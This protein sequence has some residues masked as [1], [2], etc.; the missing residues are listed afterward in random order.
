LSRP[1]RAAIHCG[2]F[3]NVWQ[4]HAKFAKHW[5]PHPPRAKSILPMLGKNGPDLPNIGKTRGCGIL[6]RISPKQLRGKT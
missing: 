1:G 6:P 2:R 4:N 5:Q 3:A